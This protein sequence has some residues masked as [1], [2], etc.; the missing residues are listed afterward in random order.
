[1]TDLSRALAS[2]NDLYGNGNDDEDWDFGIVNRH[3]SLHHKLGGYWEPSLADAQKGAR[4][5]AGA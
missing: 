4:S 5:H 1:M 3:C 2:L